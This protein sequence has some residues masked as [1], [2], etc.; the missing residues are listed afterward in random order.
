MFPGVKFTL[1]KMTEGRRMDLRKQLAGP[2]QRAR[3]I[4]REQSELE[5]VEEEQRETIKIMNLQDEF[6]GLM[7]EVVNPIWIVWGCKQIEG[8]EVDGDSLSV[9]DWKNWPSALFDEILTAIK[10]EAELNGAERKNF[11]SPITSGGPADGSQSPSSAGSASE[12]DS[13]TGTKETAP[14]TSQ[15]M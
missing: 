12:G 10:S 11:V 1:R 5:K 6:D 2:N 15:V 7:L 4:L 3:D 8:L 14:S 13:G 9:E